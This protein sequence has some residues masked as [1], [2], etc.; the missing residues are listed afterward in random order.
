MKTLALNRLTWTKTHEYILVLSAFFMPLQLRVLTFLLA[1]LLI[2][3][4]VMRIFKVSIASWSKLRLPVFFSFA[5]FSAFLILGWYA[6]PNN[7]EV[8]K[9]IETKAPFFCL[10]IIFLFLPKLSFQCRAQI[11]RAFTAGT[12][13]FVFFSIGHSIIRFMYGEGIG[14]FFYQKLSWTFHPSYLAIYCCLSIGAIYYDLSTSNRRKLHNNFMFAFILLLSVYIAFLS[15][16]SGFLSLS[17]T[18]FILLYYSWRRQ[19]KMKV[20]WY[21]TLF[22]GLGFGLPFLTVGK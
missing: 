22:I 14:V 9:D 4:V 18:L 8:F 16:K 10:P 6:Q 1:L 20:F 3:V 17:L 21:T 13:I 19:L 2:V 12:L 15:S 7:I 11:F 5:F